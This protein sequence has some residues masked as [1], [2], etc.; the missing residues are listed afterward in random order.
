MKDSEFLA[1]WQP[2]Q[3]A[4]AK[5]TTK[6]K[7]ALYRRYVQNLWESFMVPFQSNLGQI[8]SLIKATVL[9]YEPAH[10]AK[11]IN[12]F[13]PLR[14]TLIGIGAGDGKTAQVF[15]ESMF[16]KN[17]MKLIE[18]G[19]GGDFIL[20]DFHTTTTRMWSMTED[21]EIGDACATIHV[22]ALKVI[23]VLVGV[24]DTSVTTDTDFHTVSEVR[25]FEAQACITEGDQRPM[26]IAAMA[27]M[28][29]KSWETRITTK[30]QSSELMIQHGPA[31]KKGIV[32]MKA[33][34]DGPTQEAAKVLDNISLDVPYWES[35]LPRDASSV[36]KMELK[37]Q[38]P[39]RAQVLIDVDA[40]G[41]PTCG[42]AKATRDLRLSEYQ[43]VV[44][45]VAKLFPGD[46]GFAR[47]LLGMSKALAE[48]DLSSKFEILQEAANGWKGDADSTVKLKDA[49]NACA[50]K[51][52]PKDARESLETLLVKLY[53]AVKA[54]DGPGLL[55]ASASPEPHHA[56]AMAICAEKVG[57]IK[58]AH[59]AELLRSSSRLVG[60]AKK[61]EDDV[62]QQTA[63]VEKA[64][65]EAHRCLQKNWQD[66]TFMAPY[67]DD[68]DTIVKGT[69]LA[70]VKDAK[71]V[72]EKAGALARQPH[73]DSASSM[74]AK[75]RKE[76][77]EHPSTEQWL[78][79][80]KTCTTTDELKAEFPKA[81]QAAPVHAWKSI[82]DD[83]HNEVDAA[84]KKTK[85]F[86]LAPIDDVIK[87]F[88]EVKGQARACFITHSLMTNVTDPSL[89][90][91]LMEMRKK[92]REIQTMLREWEITPDQI[93]NNALTESYTNALKMKPT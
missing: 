51:E 70:K 14:P 58:F 41:K 35:V 66:M 25:E 52:L 63:D 54:V 85:D 60:L 32:D 49:V 12:E 62:Q 19:D 90:R 40:D 86:D 13:D 87:T 57:H 42:L 88:N 44:K 22:E 50:K 83:I 27:C 92:M 10:K 84:Q 67:W 31:I 77:E 34:S 2:L 6:M 82:A 15:M 46:T 21:A 75:L 55:P 29:D 69:R 79:A 71:A 93:K 43:S 17:F 24:M 30:F 9:W 26:N 65:R 28:K 64:P 4:G 89:L 53:S 72:T 37:D 61:L 38:T 78:E 74:T 80:M 76:I 8:E 39:K 11:L 16:G 3:K 48:M 7:V 47:A 5:M 56:T 45:N 1:N 33:L 81:F 18:M 36:A 20:Q 73:L 59:M 91:N 23:G 68:D